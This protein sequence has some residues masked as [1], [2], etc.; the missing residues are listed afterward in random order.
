MPIE[1]VLLKFMVGPSRPAWKTSELVWAPIER[2]NIWHQITEN[3]HPG[4]HSVSLIMTS[5]CKIDLL[6]L[7]TS[8]NRRDHITTEVAT[9]RLTFGSFEGGGWNPQRP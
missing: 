4:Y 2:A 9:K 8:P 3:V 6:P 5:Q 1:T 7:S